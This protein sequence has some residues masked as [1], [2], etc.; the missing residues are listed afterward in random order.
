MTTTAPATTYGT[1]FHFAGAEVVGELA[2]LPTLR[3]ALLAARKWMGRNPNIEHATFTM[4]SAPEAGAFWTLW[5]D[6]REAPIGIDG[7]P[8]TEASKLY[9]GIGRV[10]RDIFVEAPSCIALSRLGDFDGAHRLHHDGPRDR[11]RAIE[12]RE[13]SVDVL[14]DLQLLVELVRLYADH[15]DVDGDHVRRQDLFPLAVELYL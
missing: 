3:R 13:G 12:L 15:A 7:E 6:G 1:T 8:I 4:S 11:M 5:R 9:E 2:E 14:D 10:A